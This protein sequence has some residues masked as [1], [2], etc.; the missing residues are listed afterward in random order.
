MNDIEKT[1]KLVEKRISQRIA[2]EFNE[3]KRD[4]LIINDFHQLQSQGK[5]TEDIFIEL[6]E[7]KYLG[8]YFPESY[9]NFVVYRKYKTYT[10]KQKKF[11]N[12]ETI[13]R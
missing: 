12:G 1:L 8:R 5:R 2:I 3:A 7:K 10:N 6:S 4:M 13:S 9:I 11:N